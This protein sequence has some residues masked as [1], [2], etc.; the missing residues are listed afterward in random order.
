M[1]AGRRPDGPD[2]K[3]TTDSDAQLRARTRRFSEWHD[4]IANN[5]ITSPTRTKLRNSQQLN[6]ES[7]QDQTRHSCSLPACVFQRHADQTPTRCLTGLGRAWWV[8]KG[9]S[10]RVCCGTEPGGGTEAGREE[11]P[12]RAGRRDRGGPGEG[13]EAGRE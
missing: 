9:S 11:G 13:T 6:H 1:C 2:L 5:S 8:S 4:V 7:H 10:S 3:T 12:R